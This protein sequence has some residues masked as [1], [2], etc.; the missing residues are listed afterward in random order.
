VGLCPFHD[1][2][3]PSLVVDAL[4]NPAERLVLPQKEQPLPQVP[5]ESDIARLIE[6]PDTTPA[7]G[8]RDRALMEHFT[9]PHPSP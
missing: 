9:P 5:N 8:I 1:D 6:S 2:H 7:L 4:H 3:E